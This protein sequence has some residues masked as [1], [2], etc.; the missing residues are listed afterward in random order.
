M[1]IERLT[2]SRIVI[3]DLLLQ[4]IALCVKILPANKVRTAVSAFI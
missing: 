4:V 2:S 1:M 3:R